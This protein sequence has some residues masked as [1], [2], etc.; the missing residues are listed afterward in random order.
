MLPFY[1]VNLNAFE[2]KF[3]NIYENLPSSPYKFLK[4][5]SIDLST[6]N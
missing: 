2:R 4:N 6:F 1:G 5:G 3:I